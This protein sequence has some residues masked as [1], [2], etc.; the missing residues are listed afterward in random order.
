MPSVVKVKDDIGVRIQ[1]DYFIKITFHWI[2][3]Y[4]IIIVY[5]K[6]LNNFKQNEWN[7]PPPHIPLTST[8]GDYSR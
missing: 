5:K 1:D 8:T 3:H 4:I 2:A 7:L 6:E